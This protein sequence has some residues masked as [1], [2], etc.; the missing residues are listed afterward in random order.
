MI[1]TSLNRIGPCVTHRTTRVQNLD[2]IELGLLSNTVGLGTNG[3]STVSTVAITIGVG[4]ITSKVGKEGGTTLKLGM[5]GGDTCVNHV[6]ACAGS[7]TVVV[8]VRSATTVL[9]GN[10]GKTPGGGR[11][12]HVCSLLQMNLLKLGLDDG[13]LLNV[14]NLM[15]VSTFRT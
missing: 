7:S 15:N 13:V 2:S 14:F 1:S 3:T 12:C 8:G 11:L 4:T 6:R 9:V 5:R 10:A